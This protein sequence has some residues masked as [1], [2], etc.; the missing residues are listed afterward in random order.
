VELHLRLAAREDRQRRE[1]PV[2]E[3]EYEKTEEERGE[4]EGFFE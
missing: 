4:R 1:E 3:A 2:R